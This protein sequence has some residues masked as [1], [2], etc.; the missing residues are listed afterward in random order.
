VG[1]WICEEGGSPLIGGSAPDASGGGAEAG[2]GMRLLAGTVPP[3]L[4]FL[5]FQL[6]F[7]ARVP[8]KI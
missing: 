7:L 8:L 3:S 1:R 4:S 2:P 5:S 6:S